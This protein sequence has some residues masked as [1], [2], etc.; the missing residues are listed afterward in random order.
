MLRK[1]AE[2]A[3]ESDTARWHMVDAGVHLSVL[4]VIVSNA[5]KVKG[6]YSEQQGSNIL[7]ITRAIE[8]GLDL[9][10][11]LA[12]SSN[13]LRLLV[14]ADSHVHDLLDTV[15]DVLTGD[16]TA[17]ASTVRLL[18]SVTEVVSSV[19]L[20]RPHAAR[21]LPHHH[22]YGARDK[23][24]DAVRAAGAPACVPCGRNYA[25]AA[26]LVLSR[27]C[28]RRQEGGGAGH[29]AA[30]EAVRVRGRAC[31]R[32]GAPAGVDV[33]VR[34]LL[35]VSADACTMHVLAAVGSRAASPE[36]LRLHSGVWSKSPCVSTYCALVSI[37]GVKH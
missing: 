32:G 31:G 9:V 12:V 29:G 5:S 23:V 6:A 27:T 21:A 20:E 16:D 33:V 10:R 13:E 34:G 24:S 30:S 8:A 37:S 1:A 36:V 22:G 26:V 11:A 35:R 28:G 18:D 25:A 19:V 7:E 4:R 17:R 3:P 14:I 2:V 15:T